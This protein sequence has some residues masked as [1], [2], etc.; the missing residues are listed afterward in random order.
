[1]LSASGAGWMAQ[2]S[3][4]SPLPLAKG[5]GEINTTGPITG[6]HYRIALKSYRQYS[7][8]A[9]QNCTEI[10]TNLR[11]I[12]TSPAQLNQTNYTNEQLPV[13]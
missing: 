7:Q 5:R 10:S 9:A 12:D 8:Q 2:T 4:L 11:A 13:T 1:M 3:R 6:E